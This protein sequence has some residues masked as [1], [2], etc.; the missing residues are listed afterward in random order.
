VSDQPE[1]YRHPARPEWGNG[2][3]IGERE[4]KLILHWEDGLEHAVASAFRDRLEIVEMSAE[5]TD[6]IN[7]A[8]TS[9]RNQALK[10]AERAKLRVA[11]KPR[12]PRPPKL[13]FAEQLTKFQAAYPGG[14]TDSAY[15]ASERGITDGATVAGSR[16]AAIELAAAT[17]G[18]DAFG[19]AE[20]VYQAALTLI[21]ATTL[22]F[23]IE[24]V[25]PFRGMQAEHRPGFAA[26]LRD[27]LHGD[28]PMATRLDSYVAA[29][30]LTD[31]KGEA[32]R[33]TWPLVTI[34]PALYAPATCAFVKPKLLQEQAAILAVNVNYQP[35]PSG[36]VYD[37]FGAV[38]K[39]VDQKLREAG[40]E[41]RDL[42]DVAAFVWA[43][44]AVKKAP[45]PKKPKKS[46]AKADGAAEPAAADADGAAPTP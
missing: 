17:L 33:P 44:L 42:M 5:D 40:L 39:A 30:Q 3:L 20:A 31:S 37:Q 32:K 43:T 1:I 12:A 11:R 25:I 21:G 19:D 15:L 35:L 2:I 10:A 41:P 16:Q 29:L 23:P 7:E 22:V 4:N 9:Q 28:G 14:F 24:G 18:P 38:L 46:K 27:L 36:A 45:K 6:R 8:V 26:A 34:L 13:S